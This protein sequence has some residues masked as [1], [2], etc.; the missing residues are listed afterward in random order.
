MTLAQAL[1]RGYFP[2]ELPLSFTTE[3]Y[4]STLAPGPAPA[5]FSSG[6]PY[7]N[8]CRHNLARAGSLVRRLGIPGPVHFYRLAKLIV[9]EWPE[10][11]KH[12]NS[13]PFSITKPV[14]DAKRTRAWI[15][16]PKTGRV[17][18]RAGHV[19]HG[20]Y[21]V[22]A[23]VSQYY[24]SIYTHSL[25]WAVRGK[26]VA[27]A[28]ARRN[29][30]GLGPEL[31][32]HVRRGQGRQ[33]VGIPI[34]PDTS[35][36]L[37][38]LVLA[39][40]D[41][42]LGARMPPGTHGF[43]Y[44][45]D[46]ELFAPTRPVAERALTELTR[47]L[48][49]WELIL[50]P[51]KSGIEELPVPIE[52]E[53]VSILR[54][55]EV[56]NP[57]PQ[58]K[59]DINAIFDEAFRLSRLFPREQVVSYA[60]GHFISRGNRERHEVASVNWSHFE[61]LLLE[62]ALS[63][64]GT[65]AKAAHLISWAKE[66]GLPI[67]ARKLESALNLLGLEHARKGNAS[68]VAWAIWTAIQLDVPIR[69]SLSR[70]IAALDDDVV[71]L[72]ALHASERGLIRRLDTSRWAQ[73]MSADSLHGEHW[74]LAYEALVHGWLPSVSGSDYVSTDDVFGYLQ[75]RNVKF[76]EEA[77]GLPPAP[78]AGRPVGPTVAA[79]PV[80]PA[81]WEYVEG[82]VEWERDGEIEDWYGG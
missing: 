39:Q 37:G 18:M 15:P 52:D 66:R 27:G 46:Y 65:L 71:A 42:E 20:R 35:F 77:T 70:A 19:S 36:V 45:D 10:V 1:G 76:Y 44:F 62:A 57:P 40:V 75:K 54:R 38:E 74:L 26:A 2:K 41:Q 58:E 69:G 82:V 47:A 5:A 64:P 68:E 51:H 43:R 8:L 32:L 50:N 81:H 4:A 63:E 48:A 23:D 28:D 24:P 9:D 67:Q 17:A 11:A 33:S 60:L 49:D 16:S 80:V 59:A 3:T 73:S 56:R 29:K 53:W 21:R 34:G 6:G 13:S 12:C 79:G 72:T 31:D 22:K 30:T 61:N 78:I 14:V 7:R 55:I 25:D